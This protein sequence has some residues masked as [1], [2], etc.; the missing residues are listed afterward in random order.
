MGDEV[1]YGA[2]PM[3]IAMAVFGVYAST[4]GN[5]LTADVAFPALSYLYMLHGPMMQ[6]PEDIMALVTARVSLRRVQ[7]LIDAEEVQG[8]FDA[9]LAASPLHLFLTRKS[10][11]TQSSIA[12]NRNKC[13]FKQLLLESFEILIAAAF[14]ISILPSAWI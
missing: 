6:L 10:F 8:V 12:L 9:Y 11:Q 3:F 1:L 4:A 7:K 5:S 14:S 13:F 2:V